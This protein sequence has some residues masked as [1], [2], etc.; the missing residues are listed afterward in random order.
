MEFQY[1]YDYS[2]LSDKQ[3]VEKILA[4]PHNEE[5]AAY[6]LH[7]RYAP[8]LYKLYRRLTKDETW[9]DDCV[10]ELF[11][12]IRGKD[13]SWHTLAT[14]EWRST[15]GY[16]LR[17]VAFNKFR[18]VLPKLI[19]N[20]GFNVSIDSDDPKDPKVQIP[21]ENKESR[22]RRLRKVMLLEAIGLLKDEDQ[23][24][25]M[26]KRVEGYKS[27]EIAEMLKMK[28][29]KYGVKK[30]NQD[31]ELVVPDEDY[32]NVRTQRAKKILRIIMSN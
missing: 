20:G 8:L 27:K 26:F 24:F 30:Y 25:V 5:A 10:D 22:D 19:E 16:W 11:M 9:F 31:H 1:K 7:D 28:W 21:N 23:K 14:F 6:L 3:I 29:Q 13:S 15:L 2:K 18:D 12:H 17:E 4:E 32:V